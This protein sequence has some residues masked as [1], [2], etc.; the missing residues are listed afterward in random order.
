MCQRRDE[1]LGWVEDVQVG[2]QATGG[3]VGAVGGWVVWGNGCQPGSFDCHRF[4]SASP[5]PAPE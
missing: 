5:R 1:R 2:A 3:T 4:E